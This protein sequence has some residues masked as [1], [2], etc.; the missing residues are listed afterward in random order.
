MVGGATLGAGPHA[1]ALVNPAL[2]RA[3]EGATVQLLLAEVLHA[4]AAT[5]KHAGVTVSAVL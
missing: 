4:V 2:R 5:M 3:L 1:S